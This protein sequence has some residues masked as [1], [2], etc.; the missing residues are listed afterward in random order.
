VVV[1]VGASAVCVGVR[2][3]VVAMAV[4]ML[5]AARRLVRVI[6]A[7]LVV[8]L[9]VPADVGVIIVVPGAWRLC[10]ALLAETDDRKV[11][12]ARFVA[13]LPFDLP[14]QRVESF[15]R[16]S[17]HFGAPLAVEVFDLMAAD[18]YVEAGSVPEVDVPDQAMALEDLEVSID[19]G[20]VDLESVR[21]M[22][23]GHRTVGGEERL[24]DEASGGGEPHPALADCVDRLFDGVE[25]E[26][27][28]LRGDCHG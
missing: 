15:G 16:Y 4:Q 22:Y 21:E 9:V 7:G 18:E 28:C 8:L 2:V 6:R 23:R 12:E 14:A 3:Y 10:G 19:R 13:E 24:E 17:G 1:R 25:R 26:R 27:R 5:M 20:L 11:G